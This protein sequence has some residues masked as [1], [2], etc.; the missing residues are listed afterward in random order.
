MK[1]R[2]IGYYSLIGIGALQM[3]GYAFG[4]TALRGL[5]AATTASPL[6]IV[7]SDVKGLET[8]ASSFSVALTFNGGS[9]KTYPITPKE[10]GQ[11]RGPYNRRNVY[12]AAISYGPRLPEAIWKS[13]LRYGFCKPGVLTEEMGFGTGIEKASVL[14]KT[15]T[16]NRDDAWELVCECRN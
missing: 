11:F 13:V 3:I 4:I 6:P 9:T 10:Y 7:F 16:A 2:Q 12:G 8:F 5:G 15:Q 1:V 14:I